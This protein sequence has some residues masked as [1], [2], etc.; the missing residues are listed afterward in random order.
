MGFEIVVELAPRASSTLLDLLLFAR[1]LEGFQSTAI[2]FAL[3]KVG[4]V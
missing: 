2:Q 3:I 4:F 1:W